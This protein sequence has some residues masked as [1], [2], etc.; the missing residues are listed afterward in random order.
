MHDESIAKI[1]APILP[2]SQ[3]IAKLPSITSVKG[4]FGIEL[5][6]NR[7]FMMTSWVPLL[8]LNPETETSTEAHDVYKTY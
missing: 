3:L 5:E 2:S 4:I 7:L 6:K 1:T 8:G